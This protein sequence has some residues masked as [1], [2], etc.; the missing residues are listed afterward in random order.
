MPARESVENQTEA[1]GAIVPSGNN[2]SQMTNHKQIR[3]SR[4]GTIAICYLVLVICNL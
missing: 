1:M 4:S 2:K 3:S